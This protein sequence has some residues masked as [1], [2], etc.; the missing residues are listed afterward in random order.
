MHQSE[1]SEKILEHLE[2]KPYISVTQLSE[3]L[4]A[5]EATIRRDLK[6][7]EQSS[8]VKRLHGGAV[9]EPQ[10]QERQ[11][12]SGTPFERNLQ[13][14]IEK[15]RRIAKK[16]AELCDEGES[17][18]IDGGSTTY[19]MCPHLRTLDLQILTNSLHI[20]ED[21]LTNG[22]AR[23]LLPGGELFR[24][25]N[26]ILNPFQNDWIQNHSA[27]TMFM[28]AQAITAVGLT[29][30]D[31]LIVRAELQLMERAEKLIVLMDSAKFNRAASLVLCPL[32][33]IDVVVTDAGVT[34]DNIEMLEQAG[35][36]VVIADSK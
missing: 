19:F 17:I 23:I 24:E 7:L 5:S 13:V 25:Q 29:Q 31:S 12:L 1:R 3:M 4:D 27:S 21:L 34:D 18:I 8:Q 22:R 10:R 20:A 36:K 32:E 33:R 30:A 14:N 16:A 2:S 11:H 9:R 35:V 15:K 28:S 26:I 6:R